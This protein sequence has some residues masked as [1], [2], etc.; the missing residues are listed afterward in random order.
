VGRALD[1]A[2]GAPGSV[3][4]GEWAAI[5]LLTLQCTRDPQHGDGLVS[6]S[7]VGAMCGLPPGHT[8]AHARAVLREI[9]YRIMGIVYQL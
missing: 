9:D 5:V 7:T 8:G 4:A 3:T 6:A 2:R 1:A